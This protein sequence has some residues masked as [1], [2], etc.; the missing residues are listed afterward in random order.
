MNQ[1]N[2]NPSMI[3]EEMNMMRDYANDPMKGI[4]EIMQNLSYTNPN[5]VNVYPCWILVFL[6]QDVHVIIQ[7]CF[8]LDHGHGRLRSLDWNLYPT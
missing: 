2:Q 8:D 5:Q 3:N 1:I 4:L 6:V 7:I